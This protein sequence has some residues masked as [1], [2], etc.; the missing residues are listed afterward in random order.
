MQQ[1]KSNAFEKKQ[2]GTLITLALAMRLASLGTS[3]ANIALPALAE[4]FAAP[5][6]QVQAIVVAYLAA[7]TVSVVVAGRLGDRYGL[8]PMLVTCL[9]VFTVASLL[10][11]VASSIGVLT[12]AR[13]VQGVGAAFLMTLAMALMRQTAREEQVGRA[14]GLLGTVSA[15]GIALGP[16]LGGVLIPLTRWRGVFWVQALLGVLALKRAA[17][18]LP[19]DRITGRTSSSP[20]WSVRSI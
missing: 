16:S 19:R 6:A 12:G 3:I 5:L 8:K 17:T 1:V 13:A 15:L 9:T 18:I 7:L 4:A 20:L 10:C 2:I 11:A 14:M